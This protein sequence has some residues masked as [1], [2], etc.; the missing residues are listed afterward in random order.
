[1]SDQAKKVSDEEYE[2]MKQ[3]YDLLLQLQKFEEGLPHI[4]GFPWYKWA[5]IFYESKN[6]ENFLCAANQIS[7]SS[8]MI[9][10]CINW[11]TSPKLWPE[12]WPMLQ[13]GQTPNQF[14]YFYPTQEV[15]TIEFETKWE[16]LFLPR[17]EFKAHPIYGWKEEYDKGMIRN[18]RFNSG[19]TIYFKTYSQKVKDLQS[20]S[21]F[22]VF[23]DEELPIE[24]L[25]ELG[26]RLNATDGYFHMVF[27]ATLGQLYWEQTIE[28]KSKEDEK[29]PEALKIQVSLYD[30]LEYEDGT[31][32]HWTDEKIKRAIAK[33]PTEAEVQRRVYGRFVKSEG[34]R[35]ESFDLERNISEPHPL[36]KSWSIYS[37]VDIGSGGQSGHPAAIIFVAVSPDCKMGR[38]FKAWRGDGIPTSASDILSKY[39]T[40]KKGMLITGQ[41]YDWAA[42]DFFTISSNNGESFVRAEKGKDL[43]E[44]LLNT[45]FKTGMLKI[46]RGDPELE[47]LVSE[48]RT[49]SVDKDKSKAKDDLIDALRYTVTGISWDFSDIEIEGGDDIK[50]DP[51]KN[52]KTGPELRR[53]WFMGKSEKAEGVDEELD[54]W[55]EEFGAYNSD[56][57]FID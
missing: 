29:H 43:G 39:K 18:I 37:G 14:W 24:L 33:C 26:A 42:K 3:E 11:A 56:D 27:T 9:R 7:K 5:K 25:P 21:V 15:S 1:M 52:E 50:P 40:L 53:E 57:G 32:S 2:A 12:L 8:T 10:K 48:L 46:Y 55:N 41:F 47:K 34:L 30:C 36:P 28:P 17:G 35:Y 51:V 22:G 13:K 54:Y 44:G 23:C 49:L 16:P 20:G 45:L 4:Y 6:R 19:V 31:K 38:V